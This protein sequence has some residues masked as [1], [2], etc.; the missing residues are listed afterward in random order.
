MIFREDLAEKVEPWLRD[1]DWVAKG[2]WPE[3]VPSGDKLELLTDC[4]KDWVVRLMVL[5]LVVE[6]LL[7][8][9]LDIISLLTAETLDRLLLDAELLSSWS[10]IGRNL[11]YLL[12]FAL[13]K[14]ESL[15]KRSRVSV[16]VIKSSCSE[17]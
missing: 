11:G 16:D 14:V 2:Q 17:K 9:E 5:V 15:S 8:F 13:G 10:F 3:V 1:N 12:A 6:L 4:L 7:G